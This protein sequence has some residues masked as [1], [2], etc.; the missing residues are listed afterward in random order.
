MSL[1]LFPSARAYH[2]QTSI[3]SG[4]QTLALIFQCQSELLSPLTQYLA[5]RLLV[6]RPSAM[7][8][9]S[10]PGVPCVIDKFNR[11]IAAEEQAKK[12]KA[13][14]EKSAAEYKRKNEIRGLRGLA[15]DEDATLSD[16]AEQFY[17]S[18][19]P[20]R[21]RN[22]IDVPELE[23][24]HVPQ[25]LCPP[26]TLPIPV[27]Y[28]V[29]VAPRSEL[30]AEGFSLQSDTDF[31]LKLKHDLKIQQGHIQRLEVDL[32]A[33]KDEVK[34]L[35]T[36]RAEARNDHRQAIGNGKQDEIARLRSR[37]D[38]L[39]QLLEKAGVQEDR[40]EEKVQEGRKRALNT[41]RELYDAR[42]ENLQIQHQLGVLK[43]MS[44][45]TS[46]KECQCHSR[47]EPTT[48]VPSSQRSSTTTKIEWAFS[49]RRGERPS[50]LS[51]RYIVKKYTS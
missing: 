46:P 31:T 16:Q 21:G 32:E 22:P 6:S 13:N 45:T 39:E 37:V 33:T 41:E 24:G 9:I 1:G 38:A 49:K 25:Y 47:G 7:A 36:Q 11:K 48:A 15:V 20:S 10:Q 50:L 26:E 43:T 40:L 30:E 29:D 5:P 12:I 19:L 35:S 3:V 4:A 51:S 8:S 2:P 18:T 34:R 27:I 23:A 28:P 42:R 44:A 17:R 14:A